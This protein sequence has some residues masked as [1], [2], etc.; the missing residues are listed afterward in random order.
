MELSVIPSPAGPPVL[1]LLRETLLSFSLAE[2]DGE[3]PEDPKSAGGKGGAQKDAGLLSTV[4][5]AQP[6]PPKDNKAM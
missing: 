4:P 2:A 6:V 1:R 3:A 5:P